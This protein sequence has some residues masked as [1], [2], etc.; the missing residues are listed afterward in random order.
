MNKNSLT[1][2]HFHLE[3]T[4]DIPSILKRAE[5][6]NVSNF[7]ISGCDMKG[8]E[9]GLEIINKYKNIYLTIG[10]HPD[11]VKDFNQNTIPYLEKLI[12]ENKKI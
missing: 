4:D 9:E 11:E 5:D 2:T 10:L 6:N 3:L 7:I 12:K 8:I 1:D